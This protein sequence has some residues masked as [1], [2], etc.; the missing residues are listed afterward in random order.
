M[1][2]TT[3]LPQ[4]V[5]AAIEAKQL[6]RAVTLL[7]KETGCDLLEAKEMIEA[8]V[9]DQGFRFTHIR[10]EAFMQN[11]MTFG[12]LQSG[13]LTNLIGDA[14]H[15]Q[16]AQQL[17][18][19]IDAFFGDYAAPEFDLWQGGT[20]KSNVTFDKLWQD[21]WGPDWRPKFAG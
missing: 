10:P 1:S 9:E 18:A 15:Q 19:E 7:R 16:V 2:E 12:W 5:I 3:H 21:A 14:Q 4:E 11:V 6:I 13:A 20:A 17:S 8:Y